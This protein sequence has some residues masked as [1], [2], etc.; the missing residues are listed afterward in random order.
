M[1]SERINEK[2]LR[3][4]TTEELDRLSYTYYGFYNVL[5]TMPIKFFNTID[6]KNKILDFVN[7]KVIF[8]ENYI[9]VL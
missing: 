3:A 2:R 6:K 7:I 4:E 9:E 1:N 8:T 5:K